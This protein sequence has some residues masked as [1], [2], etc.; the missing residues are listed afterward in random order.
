MADERD[1]SKYPIARSNLHNVR[2]QI[3]QY[4][5]DIDHR[6]TNSVDEAWA[7]GLIDGGELNMVNVDNI[8]V[9]AGAGVIIDSY[10]DPRSVPIRTYLSWD[11]Q[12]EP[13]TL[14]PHPAGTTIFFMIKDTGTTVGAP[15]D[16]TNLGKLTQHTS[17]PTPAQVRDNIF[18][19]YAVFNGDFWKEVS[20]PLVINNSIHTLSEYLR[21]VAGAFFIESGGKITESGTRSLSRDEGVYW[22]QN[23]SWHVNRKDPNREPFPE[24][25]NFQWRYINFDFSFVSGLTNTADF[26]NYDDL[27]GGI[28]PVGGS[29]RTATIQRLFV[30]TADNYWVMYGQVRHD[31]FIEAIASIGSDQTDTEFPEVGFGARL[32]GYIIAERSSLG[33]TQEKA[34]FVTATEGSIGTG[35][36]SGVTDHDQLNNILP[37][38]HHDKLHTHDGLDGSG[39]VL[40]ENTTGRTA[41]DHHPHVHKLYGDDAV[42]V[43]QH[44]DVNTVLPIETRHLLAWNELG[45]FA[46]EFRMNWRGFWGQQEYQKHDVVLDIP[47]TMIANKVTTD[48]A[49]PQPIGNPT[50][51]YPD[52]PAWQ[53]FS[54]ASVVYTGHKYVFT[55]TVEVRALRVWIP[56]IGENIS[57]RIVLIADPNGANPVYRV[58]E[59]PTLR[60]GEWTVV[61]VNTELILAGQEWLIYIDSVNSGSESTW[62][63]N[64]NKATSS[65]TATPPDGNW[66]TNV[67]QSLLRINWLDAEAIPVSHQQELQVVPNTIFEISEV[68]QPEKLEHYRVNGAYTEGTNW[69]E[70]NVTLIRQENGGVGVGSA[71]QVRAVQPVADPTEFVYLPDQWLGNQPVWGTIESFLAY[72]GIDQGVSPNIG[73]GIDLSVQQLNISDDW[74][75]V[76]SFGTGGGGGESEPFPEVPDDGVTYGREFQQWNPVY[77][78][79]QSDAVFQQRYDWIIEQDDR[80]AAWGEHVRFDTPPNF[81]QLP[82]PDQDVTGASQ[83]DSIVIWNDGNIS[84][85]LIEVRPA[86]GTYFTFNG[87]DKAIDESIFLETGEMV[88]VQTRATNASYGIAIEAAA[89]FEGANSFGFVSNNDGIET[90]R[91]LADDGTWRELYIIPS[92]GVQFQYIFS[93]DISISDPTAGYAKINSADPSLADTVMIHEET[94]NGNNMRPF[95]ENLRVGDYFGFLDEISGNTYYYIL[96]GT[97]TDHGTWFQFGGTVLLTEGTIPNDQDINIALVGNPNS[98]V[99][100]GGLENWVLAKASNDDYV[101]EWQNLDDK[102]CLDNVPQ[103]GWTY[104]RFW[105]GDSLEWN[106]GHSIPVA[107]AGSVGINIQQPKNL[108]KLHIRQG[109]SGYGWTTPA[110]LIIEATGFTTPILQFASGDSGANRIR[111]G[112]TLTSDRGEIAYS[113]SNDSMTFKTAAAERVRITDAGRVGIG[114]NSPFD[115][116]H[117]HSP[118][119]N[120]YTKYTSGGATT[121]LDVGVTGAGDGI[122]YHRDQKPLRFGTWGAERMRI[123]SAGNVGI[124]TT[125]PLARLHI[126]V[127]AVTGLLIDAFNKSTQSDAAFTGNAVIGSQGTLNFAAESGGY[128]TWNK[129]ATSHKTGTGGSTEIARLDSSKLDLKNGATYYQNGQPLIREGTWTPLFVNNPPTQTTVDPSSYQR[130]GNWVRLIGYVGRGTGGTNT[131]QVR[132]GNLPFRVA[133]SASVNVGR[134]NVTDITEADFGGN[135]NTDGVDVA[136]IG[137]VAESDSQSLEFFLSISLSSQGKGGNREIF[138]WG[139]WLSGGRMGFI[140]EYVTDDP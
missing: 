126:G 41:N 37:D 13:I 23:R 12:S 81:C 80:T 54:N 44:S 5:C 88:R 49:A 105:D 39:T 46:P 122:V 85:Q 99:P 6:I 77:T 128:W 110:S 18:L 96:D 94:R 78:K 17:Q 97:V 31:N 137:C 29:T 22:E 116:L 4:L 86:L 73:Y 62:A 125:D 135:N 95:L 65:N 124:A 69:T 16:G 92:G 2:E 139:S 52:I 8:E 56:E 28:V 55:E 132:I 64:W 11:T 20:S 14:L 98:R 9:V 50:Y 32:L 102:F 100:A 136:Q 48:R 47:Y 68:G 63:Y 43:N 26:V 58:A 51:Q 90:G 111:F 87:V 10:T 59:N 134:G 138:A 30:D 45:A 127:G 66:N 42:D 76:A 71:S 112:N 19:G 83:L 133:P 25:I 117:I 72:D 115:L 82:P 123:S 109:D 35:A 121:G 84:D 118:L 53:P 15:I 70:Y 36:G 106:T 79:D 74:D 75:V 38:D 119:S 1:C 89:R 33:W 61:G 140:A 113:H 21:S 107:F 60:A 57:Y 104:G 67:Q 93:T 114:T 129:D 3:S 40:H 91:Y 120:A 27:S 103:D 101:M 131:Y 108:S 34:E 24:D 130:V 7:S